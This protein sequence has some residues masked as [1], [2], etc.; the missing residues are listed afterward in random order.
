MFEGKR[1]P[2]QPP[3]PPSCKKNPNNQKT[4]PQTENPPH[5]SAILF[6]EGEDQ[7]VFHLTLATQKVKWL[8]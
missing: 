2:Q 7:N 8:L 5:A 1:K 3:Q 4:K 6:F